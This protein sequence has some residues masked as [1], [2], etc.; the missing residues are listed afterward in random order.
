MTESKKN[1]IL[2]I[3]RKTRRWMKR[4]AHHYSDVD[5]EDL[6]CACAIASARL[7][8]ELLKAGIQG[9]RIHQNEEHAFLIVDKTHILDVTA[10]QFGVKKPVVF[11][12]M[13][14]A[15]EVNIRMGWN[16][17]W[18][19]DG[20]GFSDPVAFRKYQMKPGSWP[21]EQTIKMKHLA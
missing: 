2:A 20:K 15:K 12:T 8:G 10:T 1:K 13:E 4:N 17:I 9:A 7:L 19:F 5:P 3:A 14:E 21:R 11:L 18:S 16:T 6:S